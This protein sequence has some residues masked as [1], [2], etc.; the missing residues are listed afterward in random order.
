VEG[1]VIA[2]TLAVSV[3]A[4]AVAC[5]LVR[6]APPLV[7]QAL[8]TIAEASAALSACVD[9][10]VDANARAAATASEIAEAAVGQCTREVASVDDATRRWTMI[11]LGEH[12]A[13]GSALV[14]DGEVDRLVQEGHTEVV[15][16]SRAQALDRVI[17]LRNP[18]Q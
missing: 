5:S 10:Y 15:R 9:A 8:P 3:A 16:V 6:P 12:R 4:G 13:L 7:R 14:S 1:A 17:R 18:S 2:R 11:R